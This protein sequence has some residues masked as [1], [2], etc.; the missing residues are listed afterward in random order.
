MVQ[1]LSCD[2]DILKNYRPVSN[3]S[4]L[5]KV[6]EKVVSKR[7]YHHTKFHCLDEKF[8]SAYKPHHSTE[9]ALLRVHND[10]LIA[11]DKKKLGLLVL[12]D[13]SAAFD[14]N[15]HQTM[16]ATLENTFG[17][18]GTALKWYNS[19]LSGRK[20]T[21][22]I[23]EARSQPKVLSC[24]VPQGSILGP[25][26][27]T[28][29]TKPI[30]DII[31]KYGIAYHIYADDTQ[32]YTVF[33]VEDFEEAVQNVEKCIVEIRAWMSY[34]WLK[35]NDSKTEVLVTGSKHLLSKLPDI[36]VKIGDDIIEPADGARNIGVQFTKHLDM[37]THVNAVCKAANF[38]IW[39]ISQIR[40]YLT[41]SATE[42]LVHAFVS[43][44]LDYA[45]SL[46]FG[47]PE[48]LVDKLQKVQNTAARVVCR[49]PKHC[50]I[51]QVL[52]DLH[53][54][55]VKKRIT[56][57]MLLLTYKCLNGLAPPY[58]EEL[59]KPYAP[60]RSLRSGTQ[61]LLTEKR[62]CTKLYGDR[63]LEVAA[64][65]LWNQLPKDIRQSK[66]F[67]KKLKTHLMNN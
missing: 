48:Y 46:L 13:L 22:I 21:V 36:V 29:Y 53:W 4:F 5:S 38:H 47:I 8:Q 20:Q 54:L 18:S 24:G 51:T 52:K 45:N 16:I 40:K 28:K 62:P 23:N 11:A 27:F 56:F 12:L 25:D 3:L 64:P 1:T 63:A 65:K 35:L 26:M 55:P 31:K 19:Y 61:D 59:L 30:T 58:L 14:T 9:T 17:I 33:D 57:K 66:S 67:K 39:N 60:S 32:L 34:H 6:N 43:T 42:Q 10:L 44:K 41:R 2:P 50:H 7:T 37:T 15:D 49:L